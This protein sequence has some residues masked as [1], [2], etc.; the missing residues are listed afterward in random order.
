MNTW[1][2]HRRGVLALLVSALIVLT[3]A[4]CSDNPLRSHAAPAGERVTAPNFSGPWAEEFRVAYQN[5]QSDGQREYLA[6]ESVSDAEK[7]AV[8]EEFRACL[9]QQGVSFGDFNADGS[10]DFGLP[11]SGGPERAQTIADECAQRTG[12]DTVISM[13]YHTRSNPMH[14]DQSKEIVAC[15][16]RARVVPAGY[17]VEQYRAGQFSEQVV[18]DPGEASAAMQRCSV[19]P[20]G[21]FHE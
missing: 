1:G 20:S 12:V 2:V 9:R 6:D 4:G 5:T 17:S 14:V 16:L 21:A 18:V 11:P 10:F 15:L 13:F 7:Q 3:G 19:D 8:T